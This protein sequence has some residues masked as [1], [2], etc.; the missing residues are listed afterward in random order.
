MGRKKQKNTTANKMTSSTNGDI[1]S[2][3][4]DSQ[5]M[6]SLFEVPPSLSPSS[7]FQLDK[8]MDFNLTNTYALYD[9]H[10]GDDD[11]AM[12]DAI[13]WEHPEEL[14]VP[15]ANNKYFFP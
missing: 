10:I 11:D 15:W 14:L 9:G 5:P 3:S 2:G 4:H 6:V 8:S 1:L 7:S 13:F 12:A